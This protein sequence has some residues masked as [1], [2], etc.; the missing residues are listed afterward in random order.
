MD[1][2]SALEQNR[3]CSRKIEAVELGLVTGVG[4]EEILQESARP[5]S[6]RQQF[7]AESIR[8]PLILKGSCDAGLG[9]GKQGQ[10]EGQKASP[11]RPPAPA[12]APYRGVWGGWR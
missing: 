7:A 11:E 2:L 6:R 9:D 1:A 4:R 5:G 8:S 10:P 12:W 3:G